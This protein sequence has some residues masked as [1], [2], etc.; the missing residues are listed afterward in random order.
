MNDNNDKNKTVTLKKELKERKIS[1][2]HM[3]K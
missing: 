1:A 3:K 2:A